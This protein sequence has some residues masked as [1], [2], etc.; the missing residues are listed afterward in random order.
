MQQ[1][2]PIIP[3]SLPWTVRAAAI[4]LA[5]YGVGVLLNATIQQNEIGWDSIELRGFSRAVLRC[6]GMCLIAW[7]LFKRVRWAWWSGVLLPAFFVVV[8][9]VVLVVSLMVSGATV[10]YA[11]SPRFVLGLSVVFAALTCA[12]ILLLTPSRRGAFRRPPV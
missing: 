12:V 9:S 4:I 10:L 5:V 1:T 8:G 7:G 3:T 11:M 6:L 2:P